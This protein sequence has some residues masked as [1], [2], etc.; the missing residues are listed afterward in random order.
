MS[1]E[2]LLLTPDPNPL[3]QR[4]IPSYQKKTPLFTSTPYPLLRRSL[5]LLQ[6]SIPSY[7]LYHTL[8]TLFI[9]L[10]LLLT[11]FY[12]YSLPLTPKESPLLTKKKDLFLP[13][14]MVK[15][16]RVRGTGVFFF[17]KESKKG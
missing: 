15:K 17:G 11:P 4:S 6:K 14:G 5:P 16:V 9:I 8:F 12:L 2:I 1:K 3:L 10:F 13:L 7:P